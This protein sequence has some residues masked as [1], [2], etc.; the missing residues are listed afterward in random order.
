[1][2]PPTSLALTSTFSDFQTASSVTST[3]C[4]FG[5]TGDERIFSVDVPL[6]I[7]PVD[8]VVDVED[9]LPFDAAV[10]ITSTCRPAGSEACE[11]AAPPGQ[12]E[13]AVL[14]YA[15]AGRQYVVVD[16]VSP[17]SGAFRVRAFLRN[18]VTEGQACD[19]NLVASRCAVG[20]ACVDADDNGQSE[21][22]ALTVVQVTEPA[23]CENTLA[24]HATDAVFAGTLSDDAD[25]DRIAL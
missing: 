13:V 9:T 25:D 22:T 14:P 20:T 4:A 5:A 19:P 1:P 21:C 6:T 17:G 3:A 23:G 11:T 8:L 15:S 24:T 7:A 18:I 10:D 2:A 12:G 16:G